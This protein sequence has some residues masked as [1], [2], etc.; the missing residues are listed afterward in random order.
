MLTGTVRRNFQNLRYFWRPVWK[1]KS[2][3]KKQTYTKT[4]ACR[5]YSRVFWIF[6]PNVIKIDRYNFE[7]YRFKVCAFFLR[8]SVHEVLIMWMWMW[9]NACRKNVK[10][11][12]LVAIRYVL[13]SSKCTKTRFRPGL[14]WPH[15]LVGW[16]WDTRHPIP[17]PGRLHASIFITQAIN[18]HSALAEILQ[19]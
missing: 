13:P 10:N 9:L 15:S 6:L 8:H 14:R 4:K 11:A 2:S 12:K 17:S 19:G 1:T 18:N 7:L 5:L 3:W 16:E